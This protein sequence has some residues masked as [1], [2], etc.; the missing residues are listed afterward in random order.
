MLGEVV[1]GDEGQDVGLEAF[2]VVVVVD[3][4]CGVLDRA[5]HPF[6]LAVGPRVIGLGQPV[7]DAMLDADAIE[8]VRTEQTCAGPIPV[9]GQVGEGHAVVREHDVDLVGKDL[10]RVPQ[11]GSARHLAGLVVELDVGELRNPVD[12]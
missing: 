10:H 7:L 5:V 11:E 1:G 6:G 9:L 8:D 3:L 2:Q 4:D 12:G